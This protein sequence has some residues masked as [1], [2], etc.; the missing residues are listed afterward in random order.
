M[1]PLT[2]R[3]YHPGPQKTGGIGLLS[4]KL[5][6]AWT[7]VRFTLCILSCRAVMLL[8]ENFIYFYFIF[9]TC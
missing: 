2:G 1:E 4:D 6:L 3:V 8:L 7:A 5:A 9:N